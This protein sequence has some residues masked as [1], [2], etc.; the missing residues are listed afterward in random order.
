[1][2]PIIDWLKSKFAKAP[3]L[4]EANIAALNAGHAYGE[5][6]ELAGPMKQ[7]HIGVAPAEPGLYR[8]VTGAEAI[9]LGLV[10]GVQLANVPM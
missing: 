10:A 8:T 4:A 7:H 3:V 9:S 6:A 1:R 2:Q 5:T